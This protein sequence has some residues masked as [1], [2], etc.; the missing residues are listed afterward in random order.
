MFIP[1]WQLIIIA[2]MAVIWLFK[3]ELNHRDEVEKLNDKIRSFIQPIADVSCKLDDLENSVKFEDVKF[4][5][6]LAQSANKTLIKIL[7]SVE[8][9]K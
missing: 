6:M 1:T 3:I 8:R 9:H 4:S 7:N 2:V 5:I